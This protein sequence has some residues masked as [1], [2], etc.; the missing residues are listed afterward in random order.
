M[1]KKRIVLIVGILVLFV[2]LTIA[3]FAIIAPMLKDNSE[4]QDEIELI[5]GEARGSGS[6]ILM[7]KAVQRDNIKSIKVNNQYGGYE[8]Y[9]DEAKKD[10]F[11][12]DYLN[13]P[14]SQEMISMLITASGYPVVMQRVTETA[15]NLAEYGL[16]E[17]DNPAYY[18]LT[19]RDGQSHKVFIGKMIPTGAGYYARY[20]G[21]DAVYIVE[22]SVSQ[23]LLSSIENLMSPILFLP[24]SQ[25]NYFAVKDFILSKDDKPFIRITSETKIEKTADG[26]EYE[27]FVAYKMDYPA[28]YSVSSNYDTLIQGF[29]DCTGNAV[30]AAGKDD[31]IIS[32][33]TLEKYN[34][35]TPAYELLF[36]HS[37]IKNDLLISKKN[38]NGT[39]YV[40]SLLFNIICEMT[41]EQF[42]FVEWELLDF[43]EK[44]LIS[45]NINDVSSISVSSKEFEETFIIFTSQG[46]TTTNPVTGTTQTTTNI[47]VQLKSNGNYINSDHFRQFYMGILTTNLVTY[48]DIEDET[49]LE[50]L[51]KLKIVTKD[52]KTTEFA[53][54]P[55]ATRRCFFTVNGKGE[56]YLLKDAVEKI[57]SDSQKLIKG[58]PVDY[59][60]NN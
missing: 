41:E 9:Y 2:A 52:G 40:Y 59:Q 57:V 16:S 49:G 34:L 7:F 48:A 31:E 29:M 36:T 44:P 10:F 20:D 42:G 37:G 13:S 55:Y 32:D 45:Y 23:T 38:E 17:S 60:T 5:E 46:E 53:F 25:T 43:I 3:Y 22:S 58:E 39:F 15:A 33:E 51:A 19:T 27:D 30:L 18:V 4:T 47:Q 24:T 56:F 21:R 11:Y 54:Y 14:Y 8:F 6:S 12:K 50:C 1:I 35:K 28:E 26:E